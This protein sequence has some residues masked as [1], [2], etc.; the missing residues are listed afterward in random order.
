MNGSKR[1]IQNKVK[2]DTPLHI[3]IVLY[4]NRFGMITEHEYFSAVFWFLAAFVSLPP[5]SNL[6]EP[7][8]NI[9][10]CSIISRLTRVQRT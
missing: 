7:E 4:R 3:W 2:W 8:L 1:T 9:S 5:I 6:I 10:G